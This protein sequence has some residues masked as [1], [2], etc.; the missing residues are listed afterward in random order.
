[1]KHALSAAATGGLV[2]ALVVLAPPSGPAP[3]AAAQEEKVVRAEALLSRDAVHPGETFKAAVRLEIRPG[4]HVNDNA[5]ADEFMFATTLS[6]ED[7]PAFEILEVFYPSGRRA[8]FAYS[9]TELAVYEGEAVLGLLLKAGEAAPPGACVLKA[10][11]SYQACDRTSCLPP[12]EAAFEIPVK[13]V[14]AGQ[15][16]REINREIIAGLAFKKAGA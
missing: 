4:Y 2:L 5:P 15:E 8:K 14:P 6:V 16:T 13:V 3:A 11:L 12:Q 10:A 9:E 1:M 7:H